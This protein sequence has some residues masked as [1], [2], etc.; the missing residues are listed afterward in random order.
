MNRIIYVA[1]IAALAACTPP[2]YGQSASNAFFDDSVVQQISLTVNPN[3]WAALRANVLQNTYYHAQFSWRGISMDVGIRQHGGATRS[4]VKPNL[5][6][7]IGHY[8]KTQMFL[9]INFFLLKANN[10]DA[11]NLHQVLA[12]KFFQLMGLPA[13]REAPA[14]LYVNGE[15]F[16]YFTIVEHEDTNFLQRDFGESG[17]Y[18]YEWE[19]I[20]PYYFNNLGSDPALYSQFLDLKTNQNSPDLTNFANMI[21]A[22]NNSSDADFI[23]AVS[24]YLNPAYYLEY[25][26][27]DNVLADQDGILADSAGINNFYLYQFQGSTLY[28]L[29]PWD[30]DQAFLSPDRPILQDISR[31]VLASRLMNIPAYKG[32]YLSTLVRAA[33]MFGGTGGWATQELNRQLSVMQAA[34]EDDPNKQCTVAP[35]PGPCPSGAFQTAISQMQSFIAGRTAF[36]TTQAAA[37]SYQPIANQPTITN[38][39]P[40]SNTSLI[41]GTVAVISGQNLGAAATASNGGFSTVLGETYVTVD[42]ERA[43][44]RSV[45]PGRL[46]F[47]LPNDAAAGTAAVV[48]TVNGAL[49]NSY[50]VSVAGSPAVPAGSTLLDID[51][52]GADAQPFLGTVVFSGWAA[53][54]TSSIAS[55]SISVDGVELGQAQYGTSRNDVCSIFA[56]LGCPDIGWT[57]TLDTTL[58]SSGNHTLTL[59]STDGTGQ[60][61]AL[62]AEFTVSNWS[63]LASDP[64]KIAIDSPGPGATFS[65]G[66]FFGGWAIDTLDAIAQVS[67]TIDGMPIQNVSYGG[68]RPDVCEARA[69]APGCPNVGWNAWVDTTYFADGVHTLA[70]TATTA[71]GQSST[72]TASF[73]IANQTASNPILLSIGSPNSNE[74]TFTGQAAVGGWALDNTAAIT[75]VTVSVDAVLWGDAAYGG[76]RPDVCVVYPNRQ[77][78]PNVG[79][80]FLLDTTM[81][82]DGTHTLSVTAYGSD[83]RHLTAE[84]PFTTANA[85]ASGAVHLTLEQ[86]SL[87][88]AALVGGTVVKGWALDLNSAVASVSIYMDGVLVGPATRGISRPDVCANFASA[89]DCPNVGWSLLLDTT[90]LADGS[91][92]LAVVA[93]SANGDHATTSVPVRVANWTTADPMRVD[94]DN[95]NT[96][97]N[98][99]SGGAIVGGWAIDDLA[100]ISKVSV[101]VDGVLMGDANYGASRPDVCAAFPNRAGCP[102]VGWSLWLDTTLLADGAHTMQVTAVSS[103]GQNSTAS[104]AFAVANLTASNPLHIAIEA[105]L[106]GVP[107]SGEAAAGGWAVDTNE[108]IAEVSVSIDGVLQGTANSWARPDVC[109]V[110]HNPPGCPN[111]GWSYFIDT[112]TLSN[113]PHLLSITAST[114]SGARATAE[115]AFDVEN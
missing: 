108:A 96:Q 75:R 10:E 16:G 9:G 6:V 72:A 101:A 95:P 98:R 24:P 20:E 21:Q 112:T 111:A 104:M 115:A 33:Q 7:N 35:P 88:S 23:A 49:S 8:E 74:N 114:S 50:S 110:Y 64:I 38:V 39:Q 18:L 47:Q 58:L 70:L 31:D 42:G 87:Q 79:W 66:A 57:F 90:K 106:S 37:I 43:P 14:Q 36:V 109:A 28:T 76:N 92:S 68:S 51:V 55:L 11:S 80:N 44:L 1:G 91:H 56:A 97:N 27:I 53:S 63:S 81:L 89:P 29:I 32:I 2:A 52:P 107:V 17:G 59:T 99:L 62:G 25:A 13:P 3:D 85:T 15:L 65:G 5:D 100:S 4:A 69:N 77:S 102:N 86:P 46:V 45:S 34:A 93:T 67:M 84:A 22:I 113:G 82:A 26:A 105:P 19:D 54:E 61:A 12:M 40:V 48:V 73:T 41:A 30:T 60:H 71:A 94:I 83:G 103:A 78:C